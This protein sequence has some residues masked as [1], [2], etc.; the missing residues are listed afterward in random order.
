M[1][2][3]WALSWP[4]LLPWWCILLGSHPL[5]HGNGRSSLLTPGQLLYFKN[6][7]CWLSSQLCLSFHMEDARFRTNTHRLY[8]VKMKVP[9]PMDLKYRILIATSFVVAKKKKKAETPSMPINR[10]N[11]W[12]YLQTMEHCFAPKKLVRAG[13]VDLERQQWYSLLEKLLQWHVSCVFHFSCLLW[14]TENLLC[15]YLSICLHIWIF[16]ISWTS[17]S[18]CVIQG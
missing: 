18:L 7:V 13:P 11:E 12:L 4:P 9:V 8:P 16:C 14:M 5:G 17:V 15:L 10:A 2:K 3:G 6:W 1:S